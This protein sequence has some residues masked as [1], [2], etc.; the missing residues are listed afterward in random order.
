MAQLCSLQKESTNQ[1]SKNVRV[2]NLRVYCSD[3]STD[4]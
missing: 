3:P 4:P 2:M 1:F